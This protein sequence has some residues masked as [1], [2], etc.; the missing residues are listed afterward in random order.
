[1]TFM[2][3][4]LLFFATISFAYFFI[5]HSRKIKY[6]LC[7]TCK[8]VDVHTV[9]VKSHFDEYKEHHT[10]CSS[11]LENMKLSKCIL[12]FGFNKEYTQ[13][14]QDDSFVLQNP[15]L[16]TSIDVNEIYINTSIL[17]YK[18][19]Q[20]IILFFIKNPPIWG[21]GKVKIFFKGN[22]NQLSENTKNILLNDFIWG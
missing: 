14:T 21:L 12:E 10:H 19:I 8:K 9:L 6:I 17:S 22:I 5:F 2:L 11:K 7:P 15:I 1:M 4:I 20:E 13:N 16:K 3:Y 18:K